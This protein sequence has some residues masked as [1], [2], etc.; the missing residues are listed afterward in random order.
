MLSNDIFFIQRVLRTFSW[1]DYGQVV[2]VQ[3]CWHFEVLVPRPKNLTLS[4]YFY[5]E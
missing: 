2:Q 5:I 3:L 1:L 4:I